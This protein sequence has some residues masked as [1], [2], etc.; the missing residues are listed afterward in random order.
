MFKHNQTV[1]QLFV[2]GGETWIHH[3][4]PEAKQLSRQWVEVIESTPKKVKNFHQGEI[5]ALFCF[6]FF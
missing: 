5:M 4:M 1:L 2:I 6:L 3:Y